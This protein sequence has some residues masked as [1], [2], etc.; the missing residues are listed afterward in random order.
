MCVNIFEKTAQVWPP[1]IEEY[2]KID[3]FSVFQSMRNW[4]K[5]PASKRECQNAKN[6]IV[7]MTL[8]SSVSPT[9]MEQQPED[10]ANTPSCKDLGFWGQTSQLQQANVIAFCMQLKNSEDR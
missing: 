8:C 5:V 1:F 10:Q 2:C 9:I 4:V 7:E 6:E 3:F